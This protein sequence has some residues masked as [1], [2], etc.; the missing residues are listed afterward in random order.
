MFEKFKKPT[1]T[2]KPF[3]KIVAYVVFG[4]ISL[5]F[6][7][8]GVVPS[9]FGLQQSGAAAYVNRSAISL[10]DYLSQKE[11][12]ERQ[13]Q[14]ILQQLPEQFRE[15][16][17]NQL[18]Q[19]ALEQLI[20][21]ELLYQE[22]VDRGYQVADK[23]VAEMI[24]SFDAFQEEGS[25]RRDLYQNYLD[26]V[27][28]RPAQFEK[29]IKKDLAVNGLRRALIGALRPSEIE[30]QKLNDLEEVQL[31]LEYVEVD[32]E[33]LKRLQLSDKEVLEFLSSSEGEEQVKKYYNDYPIE[34]EGKQRVRA[35]H[36]LRRASTKE[37]KTSARAKIAEIKKE[38]TTENFA[39]LAKKWS[40]DPVS[41]EKGG[42]LDFFEK[43]Q[44]VPEFEKVAFS[45]ST[46]KISEIVESPFGFHLIEVLEKEA[47]G[48]LPFD[49][50][51]NQIAEKILKKNKATA[52]KSEFKQLVAEGSSAGLM[53]WLK[54]EGLSMQETGRFSLSRDYLPKLGQGE[55]FLDAVVKVSKQGQFAQEVIEQSGKTYAVKLKEVVWPSQKSQD[56]L[57][58]KRAGDTQLN[59]V[60]GQWIDQLK[61]NA[62]IQ[63][64]QALLTRGDS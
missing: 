25:F 52:L 1:K 42:D 54:S 38:L 10:A 15:T 53:A 64:N 24:R 63:R 62:T 47:G 41:A 27:R 60:F 31:N 45:L 36:I 21:S 17:I 59:E 5:V 11:N 39:E 37:E 46:G 56:S 2:K 48:P 16:Q 34:F 12:M 4:L 35:R 50:V 23:E 33:Q 58:M 3:K 22:A 18:R 44:M 43:G 61:Q 13:Y 7:F 57:K 26:A 6:V 20:E 55:K 51:K 9:Q 40:E 29:K 30:L 32:F 28:L 19:R 8:F 14:D 49:S